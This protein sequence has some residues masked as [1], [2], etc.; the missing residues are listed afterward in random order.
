MT[1]DVTEM[2]P[3]LQVFDMAR[4][5]AFYRGLLGFT[6]VSRTE[7]WC[8]LRRDGIQL[9]LNTAYDEGERPEAPDPARERA[10][11]DTVLYFGC[12]DVDAA[13][14]MLQDAGFAVAPP[15]IAPYGMK[16]LTFHDPD[17]YEICLQWPV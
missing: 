10:H 9:M 5:L 12:P 7:H 1:V 8:L 13:R 14:L 3:L 15:R 6:A 16:Q 4:S 11:Q 2:T 17:G